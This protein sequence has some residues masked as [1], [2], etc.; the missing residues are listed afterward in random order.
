MEYKKGKCSVFWDLYIF[1]QLQEKFWISNE[2][3][4]PMACEALSRDL[5][6]H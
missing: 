3:F 4:W 2:E 5:I 6:N 1:R